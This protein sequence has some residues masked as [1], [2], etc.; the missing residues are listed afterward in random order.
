M[1]I[2]IKLDITEDQIRCFIKWLGWAVGTAEDLTGSIL[3]FFLIFFTWSL[4]WSVRALHVDDYNSSERTEQNNSRNK[5]YSNEIKN[6]SSFCS[7]MS[8]KFLCMYVLLYWT[9]WYVFSGKNI[10]V[11]SI[12]LS[13][14]RFW[15]FSQ[16]RSASVST[17]FLVRGERDKGR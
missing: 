6:I 5:R 9:I 11:S 2:Q 16:A 3:L 4:F 15:I 10:H 8:N 7:N 17:L 13:S 12:I 14:I 1:H